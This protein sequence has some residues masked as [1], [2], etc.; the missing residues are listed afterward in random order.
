VT[1]EQRFH[2]EPLR[3]LYTYWQELRCGGPCP[4]RADIDPSAIV[5]VL[6][7]IALFDVEDSP[8]RYR[9]RLMGARIVSWYGCDLTG[10]YLDEIDLGDGPG[11]T[12]SILDEVVD[13]IV[14]GHMTGAYT[15]QDGLTIRYERLFMPLSSNGGAVD[16]VIGASCR[17][18]GDVP[19]VGDSLDV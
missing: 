11:I 2:G 9:I 13:R 5:G 14:P 6:S 7:D 17:L 1:F 18:P 4:A 16:M 12:F 10:S 3:A 19:I 8:R 15:K